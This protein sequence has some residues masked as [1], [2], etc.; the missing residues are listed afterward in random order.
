MPLGFKKREV[1]I[2]LRGEEKSNGHN[3]KG[4]ERGKRGK[5]LPVDRLGQ[6]GS[7]AVVVLILVLIKK[8]SP[9]NCAR[10]TISGTATFKDK[11][12]WVDTN[13]FQV[14]LSALT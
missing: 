5:V 10:L 12:P 4:E 11:H 6:E 2:Y 14:G 9:Q 13:I 3:N 1:S 8:T 7:V